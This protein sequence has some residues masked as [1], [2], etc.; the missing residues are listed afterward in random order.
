MK[1]PVRFFVPALL[2][3]ALFALCAC[4]PSSTVRLLYRPADAPQ[5]PVSTAP[6]ISVVQLKDARSNSY[7]G[8]RRDNTPFIPNGTVPDWVT[9]SLADELTRQGLRVTYALTLEAARVSQPQYILTGE[10]QEVWIRESSSTDISA[11]IKAFISVTGHRG[12]LFSEGVTS[13][14]SKQGLPGGAVAEELLFNTVQELVQ[15]VANKTQ[16]AIA[17]QR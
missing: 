3:A 2:L 14:L 12:K 4:G 13:S 17:A 15:S 1:H 6:S 11:S 5:I 10:L 7:I 9:K 16:Q 8:V